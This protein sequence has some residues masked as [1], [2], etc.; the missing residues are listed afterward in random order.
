[1]AASQIRA[2]AGLVLNDKL[3]SEDMSHTVADNAGRYVG[4]LTARITY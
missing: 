4:G 1:M 3:L 2:C